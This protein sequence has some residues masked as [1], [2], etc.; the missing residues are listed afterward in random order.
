[1]SP[2][3]AK[4]STAWQETVAPDEEERFARYAAAFEEMQRRKS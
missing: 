3:M 1:M 4:P 2:S